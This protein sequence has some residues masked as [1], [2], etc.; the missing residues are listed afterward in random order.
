MIP[1]VILVVFGRTI[2]NIEVRIGLEQPLPQ[3]SA[4]MT[5][6]MRVSKHTVLSVYD[7]GPMFYF[8]MS[9]RFDFPSRLGPMG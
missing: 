5:S 3:S 8:P 9:C 7:R 1:I 2:E 6:S 4:L